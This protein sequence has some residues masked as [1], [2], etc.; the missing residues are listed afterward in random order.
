[1]APAIRSAGLCCKS[2][3]NWAS[4]AQSTTCLFIPICAWTIAPYELHRV[5]CGAV[6][7]KLAWAA[8]TGLSP[9]ACRQVRIRALHGKRELLHAHRD[10]FWRI[11]DWP[12]QRGSPPCLCLRQIWSGL[13]LTACFGSRCGSRLW[14][15]KHSISI[16]SRCRSRSVGRGASS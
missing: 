3:L 14:S 15:S 11:L 2:Y 9:R 13:R 4:G 6:L 8:A 12:L 16:S 1:M 7:L 10:S 5:G